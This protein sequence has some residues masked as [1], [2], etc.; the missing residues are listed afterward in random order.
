MSQ[1]GSVR[2]TGITER[3]QQ[4]VIPVD[5]MLGI[6]EWTHLRTLFLCLHPRS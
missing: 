1:A 6:D 3:W 5:R 4:R 2:V